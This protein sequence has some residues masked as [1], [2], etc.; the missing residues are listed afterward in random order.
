MES[1]VLGSGELGVLFWAILLI[2]GRGGVKG[3]ST[4]G[5]GGALLLF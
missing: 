4:G 2:Q 3:P 1:C 5:G